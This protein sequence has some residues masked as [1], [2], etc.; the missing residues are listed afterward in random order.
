M[1]RLETGTTGFCDELNYESPVVISCAL[2]QLDITGMSAAFG[3]DCSE[4]LCVH[5]LEYGQQINIL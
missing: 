5:I 2:L 3:V 1:E 4:N